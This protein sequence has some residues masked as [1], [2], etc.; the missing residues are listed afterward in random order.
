[1]PDGANLKDGFKLR[2][3]MSNFASSAHITLGVERVSSNNK[4]CIEVCVKR[5]RAIF[6]ICV[7]WRFQH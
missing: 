3:D 2:P 4:T 6:W 5:S 1:M 7:L